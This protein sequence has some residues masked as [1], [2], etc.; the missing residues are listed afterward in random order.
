[1]STHL[2]H[3]S[4][5]TAITQLYDSWLAAVRAQDVDAI[6]AHYVE[7]VLA[8]DAILALQFRGKPAYRKHWQMCMEMCPAG[9]REPVF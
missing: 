7:D 2:E 1:M 9:E 5:Q 6:M 4:A 3:G 8:F